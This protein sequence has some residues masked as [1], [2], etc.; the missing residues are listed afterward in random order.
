MSGQSLPLSVSPPSLVVCGRHCCH[1]C[2]LLSCQAVSPGDQ[3]HI[4]KR[5]ME[6][7]APMNNEEAIRMSKYPDAMK[8]EGN[9]KPPIERE[10]WPSPP[11]AASAYPELCKPPLGTSVL[12]VKIMVGIQMMYRSEVIQHRIS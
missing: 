7:I 10:D 2:D 12:H 6:S 4:I 8:H 3:T 9:Y 5:R 11:N 1:G